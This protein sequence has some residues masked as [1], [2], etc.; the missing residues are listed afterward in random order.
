MCAN[1][2]TASAANTSLH[3]PQRLLLSFVMMLLPPPPLLLMPITACTT[4]LCSL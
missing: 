1:A 4:S 2:A 3:G